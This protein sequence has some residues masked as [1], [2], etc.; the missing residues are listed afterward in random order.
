[1]YVKGT[2]FLAR[3][4][5]L[6][7]ELGETKWVAF[8]EEYS[9]ERPAFPSHILATTEI[10]LL[11]FIDLNDAIIKRF[12]GGDPR[13]YFK[14][15]AASA[16]WALREGPF[17]NLVL[18]NDY[19]AFIERQ[20]MLF[21]TYYSGGGEAEAVLSDDVIDYRIR[22]PAPYRHVYLE[23]NPV[24]YFRRG[25]QLTGLEVLDTECVTGFS[26]GDDTV[27]YLFPVRLGPT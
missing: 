4:H 22:A 6:V 9:K 1:M 13:T 11:D 7:Q 10:D 23:F 16:E 17:Q 2:A 24:G 26:K 27:H 25:L 21:S 5:Y 19:H 15:G 8:L 20:S 3:E 18:A 12:Y 14:F